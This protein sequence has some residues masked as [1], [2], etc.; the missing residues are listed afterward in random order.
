MEN[1]K[2][3]CPICGYDNLDEPPYD[4]LGSYGSY[5]ICSCCGHEFGIGSYY[6]APV[7]RKA[8]EFGKHALNDNFF[9]EA[10]KIWIEAGCP[11]DFSEQDKPKN[12]PEKSAVKKQL[13]KLNL[14]EDEIDKLLGMK[15]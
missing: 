4:E 15:K 11:W 6:H 14:S 2:Y 3:I 1:K 9:E 12:W 8:E 5:E 13:K 7:K 10:R